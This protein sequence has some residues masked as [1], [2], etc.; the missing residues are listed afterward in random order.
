MRLDNYNY[1]K[2]LTDWVERIGQIQSV[3]DSNIPAELT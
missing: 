1:M 2:N 3:M